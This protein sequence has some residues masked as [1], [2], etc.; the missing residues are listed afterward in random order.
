MTSRLGSEIRSNQGLAYSVWS[1]YGF[2][3]VPGI[4]AMIAQTEASQAAEVAQ[5][6]QRIL[7]GLQDKGVTVDEVEN[8]KK[9]IIRS[10]LFEYE[11]RYSIVQDWARFEFWGYPRDYLKYFADKIAQV[12]VKGVNRVLKED[13]HPDK[14]S[15]M[16]VGPEKLWPAIKAR[17]PGA[18]KRSP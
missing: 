15:V 6:M 7:T 10:L 14:L 18:E 1:R 5:T 11:S 13:F 12:G 9:A 3:R 8:A 4:F 2:K 17:Q 16:I